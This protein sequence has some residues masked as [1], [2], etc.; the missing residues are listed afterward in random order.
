MEPVTE[1]IRAG[2]IRDY[3]ILGWGIQRTKEPGL[4]ESEIGGTREWWNKS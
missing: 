3:G 4:G 2:E 1:G